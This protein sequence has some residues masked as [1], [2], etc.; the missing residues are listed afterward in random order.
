[1]SHGDVQP[2][3]ITDKVSST[4]NVF[5]VSLSLSLSLSL[6]FSVWGRG[7]SPVTTPILSRKLQRHSG[8]VDALWS[9]R[10]S[11]RG[12][13]CAGHWKTRC[14]PSLE[15][16]CSEDRWQ[17]PGVRCYSSWYLN[18]FYFDSGLGNSKKKNIETGKTATITK[19][20]Y[21]IRMINGT[22]RNGSC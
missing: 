15:R 14:P 19:T 1:M 22:M 12:W 7:G 11:R 4:V 18:C 13:S 10:V 21:I 9:G 2:T 17:S 3:P 16:R 8:S 6:L 20:F 5:L